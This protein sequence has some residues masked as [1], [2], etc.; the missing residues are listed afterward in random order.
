[1]LNFFTKNEQIN[2]FLSK[3][4]DSCASITLLTETREPKKL[5]TRARALKLRLVSKNHFRFRNYIVLKPSRASTLNVLNRTT[6]KLASTFSD[7]LDKQ[8]LPE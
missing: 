6:P 4:N 8:T 1:M 5:L 3:W 7:S 2:L